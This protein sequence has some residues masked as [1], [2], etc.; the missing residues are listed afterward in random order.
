M[1][2]WGILLF[3]KLKLRLAERKI[4]R[5][6][7]IKINI[8][9]LLGVY[10]VSMASVKLLMVDEKRMTTDL[11]NAGYKK[12]GITVRTA[13]SFESVDRII[14]DETIDVIVF[15]YDFKDIDSVQTCALFKS[16]NATADIPIIFTS[17][18]GLPKK[19]LKSHLGPDLF[20]EQP[21]PR[22]YFIEKVKTLLDE[23]TRDTSR[24]DHGGMAIFDWDGQPAQCEIQD[25]SQSGILLNTDIDIPN[26]ETVSISFSV[27]GYKKPIVVD[28][29][30]VRRVSSD[31]SG[32]LPGLGVRFVTF[33]SDSQRRLEKYILSTK[34]Q[35]P[36]L[37]YYL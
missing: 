21:V 25:L 20:V 11:D 17:V 31:K 33:K 30:V 28:G 27:A 19:I 36:K 8:T 10:V 14:K 29:E 6:W 26:G 37:V 16:Q 35:D 5:V 18:Q 32:K 22:S 2:L 7:K 4:Y 23:K 1:L 12:L 13:T 9:I 3:F 34:K 15:N 24:V